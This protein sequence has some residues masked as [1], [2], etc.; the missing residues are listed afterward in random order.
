MGTTYSLLC[1]AC[2]YAN[3]ECCAGV[4]SGMM[5]TLSTVHCAT[6]RQLY[7]VPVLELERGITEIPIRC[8]NSAKHAVV[9]WRHPGPCPVCG[10]TLSK[11]AERAIWD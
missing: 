1:P 6:C 3:P 2:G 8:P 10:H 4:E 7:D 11:L 9:R 5:V